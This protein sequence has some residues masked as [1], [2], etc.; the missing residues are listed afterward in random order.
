MGGDAA[1][2][3]ILIVLED[4]E[5][6]FEAEEESLASMTL[7]L[8]LSCAP[9]REGLSQL[10]G[11]LMAGRLASVEL[12]CTRLDQD[13]CVDSDRLLVQTLPAETFR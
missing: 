6:C 1:N 4:I 7:K 2:D 11:W 5:R 9:G 13:Q 12:S 8:C 3:A 10:S